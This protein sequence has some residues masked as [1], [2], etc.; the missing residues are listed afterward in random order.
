MPAILFRED[1]NH[2][3]CEHCDRPCSEPGCDLCK[4]HY[5]FS[6]E[7]TRLEYLGDLDAEDGED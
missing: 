4:A 1:D 3:Y 6:A 2:F 7:K 5:A